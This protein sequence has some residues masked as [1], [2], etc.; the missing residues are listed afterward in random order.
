[1]VVAL[2]AFCFDFWQGAY[3]LFFFADYDDFLPVLCETAD[4]LVAAGAGVPALVACEE[5]LL[6]LFLW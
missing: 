1:M 3:F 2:G 4:D 6:L 5:D